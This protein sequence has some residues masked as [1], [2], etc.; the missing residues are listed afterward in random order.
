MHI[1]CKIDN[2]PYF[3]PHRL[4][5]RRQISEI[6]SPGE[7][8]SAL[9]DLIVRFAQAGLIHGDFNEFNILIRNDDSKPV[10]IDFPQ[11][12]STSHETS[13]WYVFEYHS[14]L[15][16]HHDFGHPRY[17]NRD[18][19]CI[20]TFFKRRFRYESSIYPRFRTI[21]ADR[22]TFQLDVVARASWNRNKVE[23]ED[24][25][26]ASVDEAS[27][28]GQSEG[29]EES[30]SEDEAG[31]E[32]QSEDDEASVEGSQSE[33]DEPSVHQQ[34]ETEE[35]DPPDHLE[36]SSSP[37]KRSVPSI[38]DTVSSHLAKTI[39]RQERKYHSKGGRCAGRP[40]GSK[41]KQD[42]R[43]KCDKSGGWD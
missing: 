29:V 26:Q 3:H 39:A 19:S 11:M 30:Q 12:V 17:F 6:P 28:E 18:V 38:K 25:D 42:I 37:D 36:S 8:Y 16:R 10:V 41:A 43:V 2:F 23:H 7:L 20:R 14:L 13:E 9:M 15:F 21:Q 4:F 33:D 35:C 40:Q 1:L 27:V 31:V 32:G 5:L 22:K 24:Q 34:S